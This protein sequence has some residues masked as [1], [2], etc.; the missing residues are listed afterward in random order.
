[1][2]E[3]ENIK[4]NEE[5][6]APQEE[7]KEKAGF[8]EEAVCE[9]EEAPL[10]S[11][12]DQS[13]AALSEA[14]FEESV[15]SFD[16]SSIVSSFNGKKSR[17]FTASFLVRIV[18]MVSCTALF[19]Y[20]AFTIAKRIGDDLENKKATESLIDAIGEKSP[21]TRLLSIKPS[22]N[23]LN[24]YDSLGVTEQDNK[25]VEVEVTTKYDTIRNMIAE[26]KR[27]NPDTYGWIRVLGSMTTINYP[28]MQS[29][30]NKFYLNYNI[31][32][33]RNV[34]GAIFVDYRNARSHS[35]NLNVVIYGHCM[36]NGSM[37][38]PIKDWYDSPARNSSAPGVQI[39]IITL[40]AVYVYDIAASYISD[41]FAEYAKISFS[42][43]SAFTSYIS[44]IQ[45]KSRLDIK[46]PYDENSRLITLVTCANTVNDDARYII[47]GI[48]TKI[49]KYN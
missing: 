16:P 26:R 8:A 18:L 47:Q 25:W 11:A 24:L 23:L 14:S 48:L 40:D 31:D 35:N 32:G 3:N 12:Y 21:L 28:I 10:E 22:D 36:T 49:V 33:E 4:E 43:I 20:C 13:E 9:A 15:E 19:L 42:N 6:E 5:A 46:K 30:D 34:N 39:E 1:M 38:R 2:N 44:T 45:K 41:D 17:I 37:F 29:K 27:I 7:S